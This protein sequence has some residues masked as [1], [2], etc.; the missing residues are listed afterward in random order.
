MTKKSSIYRLK[1]A[2]QNYEWGKIGSDSK[3]AQFAK[4]QDGFILE[5]DKPYAEQLWIKKKIMPLKDLIKSNQ[6][7]ITK[8]IADKYNQDLPFLFKVLSVNKALSI[9]AHPDK[10][11]GRILFDV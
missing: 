4:V 10:E 8:E 1:N 9:Q 2:V 5:N 7:L 11:L 3:V 6:D